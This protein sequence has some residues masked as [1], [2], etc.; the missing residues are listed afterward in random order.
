[1]AALLKK[2]ID[3]N[4]YETWFAPTVFI[5]QEEDVLYIKVPN[6]YFK[7]WLSFHYSSEINS[8]SLELF[9]KT[10]DIKYIFDEDQTSFIRRSPQERRSKYGMLLNPNLNP[11]TLINYL[12][13]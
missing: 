13:R 5:G 2:K 10:I 12:T 4:S 9:G 8:C 3:R 7:D 6:S 1:M 11:C